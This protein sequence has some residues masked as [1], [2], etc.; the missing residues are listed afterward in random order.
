M[1][2]T[3]SPWEVAADIFDPPELKNVLDPLGWAQRKGLEIWS[4]QGQI[5]ESVRDHYG[6]AVQSCHSA[7]KSYTAAMVV[8]WWLDSHAPGDAFVI[9]TAP[10]GAQVKAI[11]WKEIAVMHN[12]LGL[13]GRTNMTEWY[14]NEQL[15]AFGRKPNAY[16]TTAFQGIHARF[17]LV[18]MDE[19]CGIPKTLWDAADSIA[20]NEN[21]RILAIGN[22][23][24]PDSHFA[25]V[26]SSNLWNTIQ[27]SAFDTPNLTGEK[28]SK[29]LSELLVSRRYVDRAAADWGETSPLYISKVTGRFP[30]DADNGTVPYSWAE[31]C[32]E[33]EYEPDGDCEAGLD[34]ARDGKDKAVLWVRRGR[35]A[36]AKYEWNHT[37][38]PLE[39]AQLV[40]PKLIEHR[41]SALKID[42]DGLGWGVS[43]IFD[44]WQQEG[45]HNCQSIPV[46]GSKAPDSDEAKGL[47]FN[48]R[49]QM[50]WEARERTRLKEWDLGALTDDDIADLCAPHYFINATG[51][52]QIE[53]KEELKKRL[54]RSPD[55]GDALLLAFQVEIFQGVSH[56]ATI[57]SINILGGS[58]GR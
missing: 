45:K 4:K 25:K 51:K 42:A 24:D 49:A 36:L 16:D 29:R 32:R 53:K 15:V 44:T 17:V 20:S 12:D 7:G 31:R 21:G 27:I 5:I 39:L 22:P 35:V 18:V 1:P 56:A 2:E 48:K 47:Y 10:T 38:D 14:I 55:S 19:A 3:P 41:C 23:D 26:C 13:R 58:N 33:L 11:L 54:G 43:G 9:T 52:I 37:P 8:A 46:Y 57:A 34:P 6:T 50:W 30:T 40:L 28:V